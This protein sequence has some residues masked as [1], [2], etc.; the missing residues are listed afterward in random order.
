MLKITGYSDKISVV[1]GEDI[2]FYVHCEEKHYTAQLVRIRC[3]DL[4]PEGP[5]LKEDKIDAPINNQYQGKI[6]TIHSG[7]YAVI[8]FSNKQHQALSTDIVDQFCF[9]VYVYPTLT[10]KKDQYIIDHFDTQTEE[11]FYLKL[12]EEGI[13]Q[14]KAGFGKNSSIELSST[15]PLMN[16]VTCSLR[17]ACS[18]ASKSPCM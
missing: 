4:N 14:A 10:Q 16:Q 1:A 5:G 6:Q 7:S 15:L 8:P 2:R 13:L 18:T 11:G 17:L 12:D 9:E 3:G